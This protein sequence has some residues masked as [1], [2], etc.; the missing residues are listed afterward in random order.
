MSVPL[1]LA[2]GQ[3]RIARPL[4]SA[5]VSL[6]WLAF[7]TQAQAAVNL[8]ASK[9]VADDNG[10]SPRPSVALT[11]TLTDTDTGTKAATNMDVSDPNPDG[12]THLP[13]RLTS[14]DSTDLIIHENPPQGK[15][16]NHAA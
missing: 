14:N 8:V 11:Y 1:R 12:T 2:V 16:A 7:A 6:L 10:G 3:G 5:V 13:G 15:T 9:T 4:A